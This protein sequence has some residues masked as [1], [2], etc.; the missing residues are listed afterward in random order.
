MIYRISG[1]TVPGKDYVCSNCCASGIRLWRQS[2]VFLDS[3]SLLCFDCATK[4]QEKQIK[5]YDHF[6][7]EN[8]PTIGDLLPARPTPDGDTFWG[9]TSGDVA[10]WYHLPQHNDG[11]EIFVVMRERDRNIYLLAQSSIRE[12]ELLRRID[13]L[14]GFNP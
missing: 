5:E 3:V 6:H 2:H 11:R 14:K 8:D 4:D 13:A 1:S 12:L 7:E 9:H 10:W